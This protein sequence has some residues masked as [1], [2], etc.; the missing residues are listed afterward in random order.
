MPPVTR[1]T[2]ATT[3]PPAGLTVRALD[4]SEAASLRALIEAKTGETRWA[5]GLLMQAA[6]RHP[7][8][9]RLQN[10]HLA[11]LLR[12]SLDP[13]RAESRTSLA[14][15]LRGILEEG[16]DGID[17]G[18]LTRRESRGVGIAARHQCAVEEGVPKYR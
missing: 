12:V 9:R 18:R 13:S 16:D 2:G 11:S 3:G 7:S 14:A 4:D 17:V 6:E 8:D 1:A 5:N 10:E 15:A